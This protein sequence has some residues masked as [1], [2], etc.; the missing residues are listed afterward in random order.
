MTIYEIKHTINLSTKQRAKKQQ[1]N[2]FI[3]NGLLIA[4]VF[5]TQVMAEDNVDLSKSSCHL[6][7]H[8][9]C[10]CY[11]EAGHLVSQWLYTNVND[12]EFREANCKDKRTPENAISPKD[13]THTLK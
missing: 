11:D 1:M 6:N 8:E 12:R 9:M 10:Q 13:N 3:I 5:S 2:M 7:P 4:C